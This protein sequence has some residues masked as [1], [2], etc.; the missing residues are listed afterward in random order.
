MPGRSGGRSAS[1]TSA[2]RSTP[3]KT[4]SVSST[5][6]VLNRAAWV[7]A[8]AGGPV[9]PVGE[10]A[11]VAVVEPR[12]SGRDRHAPLVEETG[13]M[14]HDEQPL[15]DDLAVAAAELGHVGVHRELLPGNHEVRVRDRGF[16]DRAAVHLRAASRNASW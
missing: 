4:V 10:R 1:L 9:G 11:A 14:H 13:V 7:A 15:R 6:A 2:M 12:D 8:G 16:D 3:W 5:I